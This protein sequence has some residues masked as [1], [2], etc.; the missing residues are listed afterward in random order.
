MMTHSRRGPWAAIFIAILA[1]STTLPAQ[2]AS[3]DDALLDIQQAWARINYSAAS[4]DRKA[5]E[6]GRQ[7]DRALQKQK[8]GT[9]T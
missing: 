2:A 1:L 3:L 8:T 9:P 7:L 4:S 5:D 6:F